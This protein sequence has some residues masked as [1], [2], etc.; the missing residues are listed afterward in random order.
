VAENATNNAEDILQLAEKI[1]KKSLGNAKQKR[2][3]ID[4]IDFDNPLGRVEKP[5]PD[6]KAAV[7][8][9]LPQ[10]VPE[11]YIFPQSYRLT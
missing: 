2:E 1:T 9:V 11:V 4:H 3:R 7:Q 5:V 10:A 8:N 6:I